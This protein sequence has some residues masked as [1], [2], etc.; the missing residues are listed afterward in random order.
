MYIIL[1][2]D[3]QVL[4]NGLCNHTWK[5]LDECREAAAEACERLG[6]TIA[7]CEVK[8]LYTYNLEL[9]T[10][11]GQ[12]QTSGTPSEPSGE[13]PVTEEPSEEPGEPSGEPSEQ[14]AEGDEPT[15]E[16]PSEEPTE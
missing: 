4:T 2:N 5:Y 7:V 12:E 6:E 9:V 10:V 1:K 15:S 14:P 16:K 13:Q 11:E 8:P 3:K